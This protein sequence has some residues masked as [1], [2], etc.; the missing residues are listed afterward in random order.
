M[1]RVRLVTASARRRKRTSQW[2][3]G[4]WGGGV[5]GGETES[6][7]K[8]AVNRDAGIVHGLYGLALCFAPFPLR[9]RAAGARGGPH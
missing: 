3:T 9:F 2:A 8:T 5:A 7:T 4:W 1:P 6:G